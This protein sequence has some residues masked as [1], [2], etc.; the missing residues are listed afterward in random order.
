MTIKIDKEK[1]IGCGVCETICP[2]VFKLKESKAEIISQKDIPCI[3][4][5]INSCPTQAISK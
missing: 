5:A 1:C 3:E 4:D 2:S